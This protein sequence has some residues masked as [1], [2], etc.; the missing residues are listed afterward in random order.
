MI[1]LKLRYVRNVVFMLISLFACNVLAQE[2]SPA[3]M[4]PPDPSA[5]ETT[6]QK[7]TT[8][9]ISNSPI[10]KVTDVELPQIAPCLIPAIS[11]NMIPV[12]FPGRDGG[13]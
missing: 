11:P 5:T 9:V 6:P 3:L 1:M 10:A 7:D 8:N 4:G 2:N 12:N 13:T